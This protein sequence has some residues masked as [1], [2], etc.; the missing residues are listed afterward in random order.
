[1][2]VQGSSPQIDAFAEVPVASNRALRARV[3]GAWRARASGQQQLVGTTP[4]RRLETSV[5]RVSVHKLCEWWHAVSAR[6]QPQALG[7]TAYLHGK[8]FHYLV[9]LI[10][11]RSYASVGRCRGW[12]M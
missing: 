2:Y 8:K 3:S 12:Y 10:N 11:N 5:L 7:E 4:G 9:H 6:R 1:M